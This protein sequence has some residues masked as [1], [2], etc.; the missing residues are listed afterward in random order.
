MTPRR[1]RHR[2]RAWLDRAERSAGAS[3]FAAHARRRLEMGERCYGDRWATV[4]LPVLLRELAEEAAD[5]GAWSVLAA[6]ALD[7]VPLDHSGREAVAGLLADA[8][9]HGGRAHAAIAAA[10]RL[11]R[12]EAA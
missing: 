7:G 3:G 9:E 8:A 11:D 12:G 4:G 2:E 5:L 1:D 10:Q 6:Q